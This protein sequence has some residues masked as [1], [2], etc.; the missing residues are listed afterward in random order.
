MNDDLSLNN[1]S[2][3][4]FDQSMIYH[5]EKIGNYFWHKHVKEIRRQQMELGIRK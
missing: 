5:V 4:N 3:G 2:I 1:V